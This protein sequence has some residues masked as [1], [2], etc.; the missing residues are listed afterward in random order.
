M[1]KVFS[2]MLSGLRTGSLTYLLVLLLDIQQSPVS[3]SNI[4]SI[5]V[6]SAA[7]GLVS[8]IFDS[9][10][11]S[12]LLL[13][14]V[15]CLATLALVAAMMVYNGWQEVL[16]LP[17]FWIEYFLIYVII[18]CMVRLDIYLKTQKINQA[19]SKRHQSKNQ[20]Q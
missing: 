6:M 14:A 8:L 3:K 19:L 16:L 18:W 12:F 10:R 2:A 13:L 15:H 5:L 4:I 1:K 20:E 17:R 7:I 11:F 9:E